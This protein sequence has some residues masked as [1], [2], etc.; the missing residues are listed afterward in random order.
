MYLWW[1]HKMLSIPNGSG[2]IHIITV[3]M[4][5]LNDQSTLNSMHS[6]MVLMLVKSRASPK[7]DV[8]SDSTNCNRYVNG[9]GVEVNEAV[10]S[11]EQN[12]IVYL[13][14]SSIWT[15]LNLYCGEI[16]FIVYKWA[17][18]MKRIPE[19][20]SISNWFPHKI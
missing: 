19:K 15:H 4:I 7:I 16:I 14:L 3:C 18:R 12:R 20:L 5:L 6:I 11:V 17:P 13:Y 9:L 1:G 10:W 2:G 8:I